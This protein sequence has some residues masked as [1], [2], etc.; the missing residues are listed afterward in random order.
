MMFAQIAPDPQTLHWIIQGGS[1]GLIAAIFIWS[2]YILV[3]RVLK[4]FEDRDEK[5]SA[6]IDRIQE[7]NDRELDRR[8]A[9]DSA[10]VAAMAA[11]VSRLEMLESHGC[12]YRANL[13]ATQGGSGVYKAKRS[14][15]TTE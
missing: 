9:A 12:G 6:M 7:R 3:P 2:G 10:M 15:P 1:F 14:L 8:S 5:F 11:I 4:A 13:S